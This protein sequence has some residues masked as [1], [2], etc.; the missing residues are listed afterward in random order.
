VGIKEAS[1]NMA[2]VEALVKD[3]KSGFLLSSGDD[4]SALDFIQRGGHGV[5]SVIS[6]V[7][8]AEFSRLV[9]ATRAGDPKARQQ[10]EKFEG[11]N[12]LL[13]VE[14]NPIPV[15]M[16]LYLMGVID[17]PEMRLPLMPLEGENLKTV[18]RELKTLGLI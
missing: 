8:P 15:K 16:M 17:S 13:G 9:G 6:H 10:Y 1:G 12:K 11:L 3:V 7:I 4:S 18:E 5:I 14:A 2:I